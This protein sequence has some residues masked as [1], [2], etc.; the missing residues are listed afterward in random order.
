MMEN[1]ERKETMIKV[2]IKQWNRLFA[3]FHNGLYTFLYQSVFLDLL[4]KIER[5]LRRV[6]CHR[7]RTIDTCCFSRPWQMLS[8]VERSAKLGWDHRTFLLVESL[9]NKLI[10][11]DVCRLIAMPIKLSYILAHGRFAGK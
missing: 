7:S 5:Q 3:S 6:L 8:T 11:K 4:T 9:A 10:T 1:R 2:Q